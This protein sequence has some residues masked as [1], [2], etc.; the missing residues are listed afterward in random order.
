MADDANRLLH[1][2]VNALRTMSFE[3]LAQLANSIETRVKEVKGVD[4]R[5]YQISIRCFYDD[6]KSRIIRVA[7]SIYSMEPITRK[8]WEVWRIPDRAHANA[9]FLMR[10]DG[11]FADETPPGVSV[12]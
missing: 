10:P 6:K 11:S 7:G 9:D 4:G 12:S 1:E 3:E 2:E 8:W 5:P